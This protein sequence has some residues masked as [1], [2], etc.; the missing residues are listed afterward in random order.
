[1]AAD[2]RQH[3]VIH[4]AD[5]PP[6]LRTR[7]IPISVKPTR[8]GGAVR[9]AVASLGP[10][11]TRYC[12]VGGSG[13]VVN[14]AIFWVAARFAPYPVA[15]ALAFAVAA[16]SNF[17]L[18]RRWTFA[19]TNHRPAATQFRRFLTVSVVALGSDLAVLSLLVE[20]AALPKF[21]SALV[22]IAFTTPVSF[23]A[24]RLWTFSHR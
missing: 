20:S 13:Y 11:F 2:D 10:A 5:A 16:T 17:C 7:V 3:A 18:N 1:V 9:E 21:V 4:D 22:A 8:R 15:F 14:A 6:A 19:A 24:N 12:L 23:G